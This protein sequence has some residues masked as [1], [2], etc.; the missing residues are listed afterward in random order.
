MSVADR[1]SRDWPS[2]IV[3]VA[4]LWATISPFLFNG[5]SIGTTFGN[6]FAGLLLLA[7]G[8]YD[9]YQKQIWGQRLA[10]YWAVL[11][12]GAWMIV[13][14]YVLLAEPAMRYG[15]IAVG[16]LAIVMAGY[17]LFRK[18]DRDLLVTQPGSGT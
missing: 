2:V 11:G 9:V 15:N 12:L 3:A 18:T 13:S 8:A 14:P 4:G 17:Q 16:V 1:V 10:R 5:T 7:Y 6:I